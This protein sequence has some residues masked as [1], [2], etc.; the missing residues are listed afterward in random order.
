[1]WGSGCTDPRIW[2]LVGCDWLASSLGC[3]PP[4][5]RASVNHWVG[6]GVGPKTCLEDVERRKSCSYRDSNCGPS[7]VQ[8]V[9]T[10]YTDCAI[11]APIPYKYYILRLKVDIHVLNL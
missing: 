1:M 3:F 4:W 8:P 7:T 9:A 5:E 10:R 11:L 2:E 6:D